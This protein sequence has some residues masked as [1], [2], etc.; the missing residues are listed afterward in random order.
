MTK[1]TRIE[2]IDENGRSY[3]NWEDDNDVSWQFQDDGRTLKVFVNKVKPKTPVEE[4]YKNWWGEYPGTEIWTD[5]DET[6]WVGFKAGYNAAYEETA[7]EPEKSK[8]N[9]LA[10]KLLPDDHPYKIADEHGET[11]PYK[12]YL[13]SVENEKKMEEL[14]FVKNSDGSWTARPLGET[15]Q[16]LV[17]KLQEKEWDVDVK[18][19]LK[20][21]TPEQV[22][23]GLKEA[24]R[25]AIKQGIIPEVDK[26][27]DEFMD[28]MVA[29]L[30]GQ[31]LTDII[32]NWWGN[33]FTSNEDWDAE[34][35]IEH[36]VDL[37]E[38]FLPK[39]QNADG[40]Q[41]AYVESAVEGFNDC[42]NTI[43]RKLR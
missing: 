22:S 24:F 12:Q 2:V 30:K 26:V 40:S 42:L 33:V 20:P 36:L 38:A 13:N 7:Q 4:A 16:E 25:E 8:I 21:Q 9:D 1:I 19:N 31:T 11:N 14:G 5:Y 17:K 15:A 37:I 43:K 34:N 10:E 6:R 35:A 41:N 28:E 27:S 23:D 18:T 29:K 32:W 39:P 3:V